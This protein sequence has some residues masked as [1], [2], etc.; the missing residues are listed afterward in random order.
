MEVHASE[1]GIH[2][3]RDFFVHMGTI[4]LGLLIALA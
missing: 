3:W 1:H 2:S 4:C